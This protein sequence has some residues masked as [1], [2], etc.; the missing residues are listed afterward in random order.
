MEHQI[1]SMLAAGAQTSEMLF[2]NLQKVGISELPG[3]ADFVTDTLA[4]YYEQGLIE[5]TDGDWT[6]GQEGKVRLVVAA[7]RQDRATPY[8]VAPGSYEGAELSVTCL[9]K[10]AYDYL[11]CPSLIAG[12]LVPHRTH[13]LSTLQHQ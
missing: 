13:N 3:L 2:E 9:R 1:L 8:K 11:A 7:Q 6:L 10:G 4:V 12:Q 5:Y